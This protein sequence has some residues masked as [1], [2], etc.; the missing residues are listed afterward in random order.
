[1]RRDNGDYQPINLDDIFEE[2]D[3]LGNWLVEREDLV[4]N[5][6]EFLNKVMADVDDFQSNEGQNSP[7][8]PR[9][10]RSAMP[11]STVPLAR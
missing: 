8:Q 6:T 5:D 10:L 11:T 4:L 3:P 9:T 2:D 1:M 7:P